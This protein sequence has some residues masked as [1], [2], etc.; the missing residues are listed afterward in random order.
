MCDEIRFAVGDEEEQLEALFLEYEMGLAGDIEE[1]VLL[2]RGEQILAG[3]MLT[4]VD[5]DKFH[6]PLFAVAKD[7][8]GQGQGRRLLQ[9]LLKAPQKY[10]RSHPGESK[11]FHLVTTVAKGSAAGF[12]RKNGFETCQFSQLAP[13]FSLQCDRCP[14]KEECN[15]VAMVFSGGRESS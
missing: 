15:P 9:Q 12:Y 5:D 10:C 4:W 1:H 3:A 6:L 11:G 14:E 13:P 7:G 2:K 8:R